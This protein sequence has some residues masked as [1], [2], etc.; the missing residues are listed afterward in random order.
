MVT[1]RFQRPFSVK[2]SLWNVLYLVSYVWVGNLLLVPGP[3]SP[4]PPWSFIDFFSFTD[5]IHSSFMAKTLYHTDAWFS[6]TCRYEI[7]RIGTPYKYNKP[8]IG[9]YFEPKELVNDSGHVTNQISSDSTS[10]GPS[11][12]RVFKMMPTIFRLV[13]LKTNKR[14][15]KVE[16]EK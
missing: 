11:I 14:I 5:T 8:H 12:S 7:S 9:K 16:P 10:R 4:D 3:G 15:G 1:N 13:N 2:S 6:W